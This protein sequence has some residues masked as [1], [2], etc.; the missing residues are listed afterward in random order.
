MIQTVCTAQELYARAALVDHARL[1]KFQEKCSLVDAEEVLRGAFWEDIRPAIREW[2]KVARPAGRSDARLSVRADTWN[3]SRGS[4]VR[5][6]GA[7]RPA[8]PSRLLQ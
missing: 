4:E 1:A 8:T 5:R 6:I 3:E 7:Q 2:R